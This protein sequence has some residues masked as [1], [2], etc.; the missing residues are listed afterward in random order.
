[1]HHIQAKILTYLQKNSQ[2][3]FAELNQEKLPNDWFSYHLRQ[4]VKN[5]WVEKQDTT[6]TLT[7]QGK[8]VVLQIGDDDLLMV[9]QR[10]SVLLVVINNGKYV[11][12]HRQEE[13]FNGYWE[14]PTVKVKY[15]ELPKGVAKSLLN[16]EL[17][18]EGEVSFK[19]INHKLEKSGQD[20]FDDK[21]YFV[22]A[23]ESITGELT[24]DFYGGT[25]HWL[26]KSELLAKEKKH[27]DLNNTFRLTEEQVGILDV[28][29]K[30][31]N[32]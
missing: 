4:V 31:K 30:L 24:S 16:Q 2:G 14:F 29:E 19:G 13:P 10:I 26:T 8:K 11:V 1:M 12:Q 32:Y 18:L 28:S 6:Y 22:F 15:G 7:N 3:S 9:N 5:D 23:A 25:N 20:I 21:Y 17:G 27:F